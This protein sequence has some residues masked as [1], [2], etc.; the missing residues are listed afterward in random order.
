MSR[1]YFIYGVK[2]TGNHAIINWLM[3]Q[4]GKAVRFFNDHWYMLLDLSKRDDEH[5][6]VEHILQL[7]RTKIFVDGERRRFSESYLKEYNDINNI[8]SF[9]SVKLSQM[10]EL[11]TQW[12]QDLNK[13]IKRF[14]PELIIGN[15]NTYIVILR[16]PWN[17]AASQYRWMWDRKDFNRVDIDMVVWSEFYGHYIEQTPDI[18]FIIYDKWFQDI[19]YRKKISSDLGLEFNDLNINKVANAGGGSSFDKMSFDE[20]AQ[21]MDVLT[22]YIQMKEDKNMK[23]FMETDMASELKNKWNHL[24]DL[25]DI[26]NLKIK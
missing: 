23:V 26:T 20:D 24:C 10:L 12:L 13:G 7:H 1:N 15:D 22:R 6:L 11:E 19:D 4:V 9:E 2:R 14:N 25:E 16:N 8:I 17:V 18:H 5:H 21:K 3:P